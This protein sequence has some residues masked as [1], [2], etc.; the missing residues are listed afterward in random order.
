MPALAHAITADR[1]LSQ[2]MNWFDPTKA[3][4]VPR[5]VAFR[6]EVYTPH[7]VTGES[8]RVGEG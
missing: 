3:H 5:S 8:I 6:D 7:R 2:V 1:L 4:A